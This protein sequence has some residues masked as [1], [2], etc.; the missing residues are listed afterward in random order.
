MK[1]CGRGNSLSNGPGCGCSI[2]NSPAGPY[3]LTIA[4]VTLNQLPDLWAGATSRGS[5]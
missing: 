3:T 1:N 4:G 5:L 2:G